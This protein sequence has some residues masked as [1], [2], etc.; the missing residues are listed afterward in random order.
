MSALIE[1]FRWRGLLQD[2]SEGAAAHL[3]EAPRVVYAGFDPTAPS[4]HVGSLL[5]IM[6]LVHAQ[7]HGHHPIPLV[8]GG[9]GLIG[10]PSGRTEE[11]QLLTR[12]LAAANAEGIRGQLERFLDFGAKQNP[13]RMRN[14][15]DWLGE[16]R[17]VDYLRDHGKHFR[18]NDMLRKDSVRTRLEEE[19]GI[20]Y[21]EFS[22]LLLQSYDFLELFRR[23]RC[24]VQ[25]GGS[26]QWGN[27]TAGIDLIRRV[28]SEPAHGVVLPLLT[29]STGAKFGKSE[30]GNVWLDAARTSP[31]RFYQYWINASDEDAIRYLGLFTLLDMTEV[32]RIGDAT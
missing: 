19:T 9:T 13:A 28:T 29:T 6:G 10:D 30:G 11:R 2:M 21:T 3:A 1:E 18:V 22:Y 15:L 27:I 12:E 24:T 25:L 4:L 8:G 23:E 5:P 31:Y 20:S 16:I 14:N 32:E 17:M 7:R 26:D